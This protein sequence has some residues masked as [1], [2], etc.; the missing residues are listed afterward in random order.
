M[1]KLSIIVPTY[2]EETT[3]VILLERIFNTPTLDYEKE[4]IV[5]DDGSTDATGHILK[6]NKNKYKYAVLT[7]EKNR[8]KGAAIRTGFRVASGDIILIQDADLE[9]DPADWEKIL[10]AFEDPSVSV[11]FGSR[12]LNP[13]RRGYW[14][15]V[16]GVKLLTGLINR[17]FGSKLTDSYTC[18]KAFRK[19]IID[20]LQLVSDRFE[21]EAEICA[22]ILKA[23][24]EIRE[25]PISY[26]PRN[27]SEGKKIGIKDGLIGFW[28]I[29]KNR[30]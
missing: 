24:Y 14:H 11:V 12:N 30:P 7:H 27:F 2:N 15:Y 28:T 8:G 16:L 3:L 4:I 21:I 9:Y 10:N 22:K 13:K 23:G 18:F 6:Q 19:N 20:G 1:K 29:W 5:I 25:V 17:L 26:N